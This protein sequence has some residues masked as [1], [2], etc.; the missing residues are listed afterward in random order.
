M[1]YLERL[2]LLGGVKDD[3]FEIIPFSKVLNKLCPLTS[4]KLL[5]PT[6]SFR[7]IQSH[8]LVSSSILSGQYKDWQFVMQIG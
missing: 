3:F 2:T 4:K 8:S 6:N 5:L 1:L 7:I